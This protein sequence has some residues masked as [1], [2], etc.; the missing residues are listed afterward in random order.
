M[1]I[2][3]VH[4]QQRPVRLSGKTV[5][6]VVGGRFC[7][8]GVWQEQSGQKTTCQNASNATTMPSSEGRKPAHLFYT[9]M[10]RWTRRKRKQGVLNTYA[11]TAA[12]RSQGC[13]SPIIAGPP[14]WKGSAL[15]ETNPRWKSKLITR[16]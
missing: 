4:L 6:K 13:R 1:S 3:S 2:P 11:N 5:N 8:H 10:K 15:P 14:H 9:E 16:I 12:Q 7:R